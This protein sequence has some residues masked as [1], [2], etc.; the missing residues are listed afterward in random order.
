MLL[1]RTTW[2][3]SHRRLNFGAVIRGA[4]YSADIT[5]TQSINTHSARN[6]K[7]TAQNNAHTLQI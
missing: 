1:Y 5:A 2:V 6:N 3:K 4:V 7:D